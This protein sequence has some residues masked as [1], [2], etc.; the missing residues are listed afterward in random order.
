VGGDLKGGRGQEKRVGRKKRRYGRKKKQKKSNRF[1][2]GGGI[3]EK[4]SWGGVGGFEQE[5]ETK[6]GLKESKGGSEYNRGGINQ[7]NLRLEK[8]HDQHWANPPSR[9]RNVKKELE[10]LDK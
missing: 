6:K 10:R 4:G 8:R 5:K 2:W 1:P 9:T 3:E 7:P